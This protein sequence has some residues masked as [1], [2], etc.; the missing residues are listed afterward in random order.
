MKRPQSAVRAHLLRLLVIGAAIA[1][2]ESGEHWRLA[3]DER[4]RRAGPQPLRPLL[5]PPLPRPRS[6]T[7]QAIPPPRQPRKP[8]TTGR[9]RIPLPGPGGHYVHATKPGVPFPWTP[10]PLPTAAAADGA[11]AGAGAG[12]NSLLAH[13]TFLRD[14]VVRLFEGRVSGA[15]SVALRGD[16]T[17]V[18]L[19]RYGQVWEATPQAAA[20]NSSSTGGGGGGGGGGSDAGGGY[21]LSAAPV[22][23][24]ASNGGG[25]PL[26]FHPDD[27]T[28][29]LYVCDS[30]RGL[31]VVEAEGEAAGAAADGG[32]RAAPP[33]PLPRTVR[34]VATTISP[35]SRTRKGER[36]TYANDL[37]L[38]RAPAGAYARALS[39]DPAAA[40]TQ[41]PSPAAGGGGGGG[42]VRAWLL[43]GGA[44]SAKAV[45]PEERKDTEP[46]VYFTTCTDIEPPFNAR[47]GYY[48]TM[49]GYQLDLAQGAPKGALLAWSPSLGGAVVVAEGLYYANGV[50]LAKRGDYALV[51]ET[52]RN[53]VLRV[54]LDG[55]LGG[56][57]QDGAGGSNATL[58][59]PVEEADISG[60]GGPGAT[61]AQGFRVAPRVDVFAD[62]LPGVPDG[63]NIAGASRHFGD[64][65]GDAFWVALI[66]PVPPV[67]KLLGL[68]GVRAAY[69][70]LPEGL[71]PSVKP[72]GAAL[73][74]RAADGAAEALLLDPDGERVSSV[75]AVTES[76]GGRLFFGNLMGDYVSYVDLR[77]AAGEWRRRR[78][79]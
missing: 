47:G 56:K 22:A 31:V 65:E 64:E 62:D 6:L 32:Q 50:A 41:E 45:A 38:M 75:S 49:R 69:A 72:W 46:V 7:R 79:S 14:N 74:L 19:D 10:Q 48:D 78:R 39:P 53:R 66:G 28:G 29:D 60:P 54:W 44:G 8:K 24:L 73:R 58:A 26:G 57:N 67:S 17:L 5:C 15:E 21:E 37:D 2:V 59:A 13:N 51:V 76:A 11:A 12:A 20:G 33:S 42:G 77:T 23:S 3:K 9:V 34:D 55:R 61:L 70:W 63:V 18:M 71:R 27:A 30:R 40:A 43:D 25:R 36:I 16:G 35:R 68:A 4:E 52:N 1:A